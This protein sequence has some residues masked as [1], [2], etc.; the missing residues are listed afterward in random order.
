M[1]DLR[2]DIYDT[3][4][5]V[6]SRPLESWSVDLTVVDGRNAVQLIRIDSEGESHVGNYV[7]LTLTDGDTLPARYM[8]GSVGFCATKTVSFYSDVFPTPQLADYQD[9]FAIYWIPL[10]TE[11]FETWGGAVVGE[12]VIAESEPVIGNVWQQMC[13]IPVGAAHESVISTEG[14]QAARYDASEEEIYLQNLA[15]Y[16]APPVYHST[17]L[18]LEGVVKALQEIAEQDYDISINHGQSV[19]SIRG[20]T[21]T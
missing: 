20:R 17:T 18:Q 13:G 14:M 16:N 19:F 2:N 6:F 5:Y 8:V 1:A 10:I 3:F 4:A 11:I 7:L 15:T 12:P 21:L 9:F